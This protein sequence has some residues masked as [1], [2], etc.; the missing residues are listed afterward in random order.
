MKTYILGIFL[1]LV[2]IAVFGQSTPQA[3]SY[4]AVAKDA[5]GSVI[6]NQQ[7]Y[8]KVNVISDSSDGPTVY[9]EYHSTTTNNVGLFMLAVGE[10]TALVNTFSD[11]EWATAP[12]F[13][14]IVADFEGS[15][16]FKS[17]GVSQ[18]LSVPYALQ[19]GVGAPGLPGFPG[20]KGPKG[21]AGPTGPSCGGSCSGSTGAKGA[22]GAKGLQGDKGPQGP[23]PPDGTPISEITNCLDVNRNHEEDPEED[24]N[25]DGFFSTLDCLPD[26]VG[27]AGPEGPQGPD[28]PEGYPGP[29]GYRGPKGLKGATGPEGPQGPPNDP[30][31]SPWYESGSSISFTGGYIGLGTQN[32]NA[33]VDVIGSVCSNGVALSSDV[34]YKKD[35]APLTAS[36]EKLMELVPVR[37]DFKTAEFPTMQFPT[38]AQIGFIAQEVETVIPEIVLT[39]ADGYKALDYAKLTPYLIEAIKTVKAEMAAEE[40]QFANEYQALAQEVEA[41]KALVVNSK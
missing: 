6:T 14:E 28:G 13:V 19:T 10:G 23:T 9:S 30:C 12:H 25:G 37:Y 8:V 33:T 16:A 22:K 34:R 40:Q 29:E 15:G 38:T 7:V 17:L 32:P 27:L 41:L 35:I 31:T 1:L 2:S 18:L 26:L 36:L 4:Q 24:T 5:N 11:I 39:K 20:S 21:A 3:F